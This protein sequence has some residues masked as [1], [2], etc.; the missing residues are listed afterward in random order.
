MN[1]LMRLDRL[2]KNHDLAPVRTLGVG[3]SLTADKILSDR[4]ISDGVIVKPAKVTV[5]LQ[6]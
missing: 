5:C 4:I 2:K 6:N 1:V 3:K